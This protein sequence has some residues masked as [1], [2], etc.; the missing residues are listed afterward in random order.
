MEELNFWN[1]LSQSKYLSYVFIFCANVICWLGSIQS[2]GSLVHPEA[3]TFYIFI[4]TIFTIVFSLIFGTLVDNSF[5]RRKFIIIGALL[6]VLGFL[7]SFFI[8]FNGTFLINFNLTVWGFEINF[9][10]LLISFIFGTAFGVSSVSI[11]A[12][13]ADVSSP[14]DRGKLQG[15]SY[16]I[17]FVVGFVLIIFVLISWAIIIILSILGVAL[18]AFNLMYSPIS[19]S[20]DYS[21][22]LEPTSYSEVLHDK[23]F[24]YFV[25]SFLLF[26]IALPFIEIFFT[27]TEVPAGF[28]DINLFIY[29]PLL[30]AF[31]MLGGIWADRG[32]RSMTLITFLILGLGFAIWGLLEDFAFLIS[33]LIIIWILVSIGNAITNVFDY[34]IPSDYASPRSRGKYIG[35]FL[36]ATNIGLLISTALRPFIFNL[37]T[38][39]IALIVTSLLLFAISPIILS[40]EPL[41]EALS[42]EVDMKGVY[43]IT[44]DGRCMVEMSFKDVLIDVDLITSALSAVGGLIKESIHSERQLKTIDHADVQ[45][46]IE[47]GRYVNAAVIADKE[48]PDLRKRLEHFLAAF[49]RQYQEFIEKWTGD[50]RPFYEAY[51]MIE[52]HFGVYLTK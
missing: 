40:T 38:T 19:L 10:V 52:R 34:V 37:G 5:N 8:L 47:Y 42:K 26:M 39:T 1:K 44:F 35:V 7:L 51:K 50:I 16:L 23:H 45:I 27:K 3:L 29:Y 25:I 22:K 32:R 28:L 30:G 49:E 2:I 13:F 24:L 33:T 12:Y 18:I 46:L 9:D 17:S 48:T 41:D 6:Y 43:V 31:A 4:F 21:T 20:Q 14:K 36:I 11:G 15:I